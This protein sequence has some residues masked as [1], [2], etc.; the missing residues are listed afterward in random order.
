M[1]IESSKYQPFVRRY[2]N[3]NVTVKSFQQERIVGNNPTIIDSMAVAHGPNSPT[4]AVLRVT[5][6]YNRC[7]VNNSMQ[8]IDIPTMLV[9]LMNRLGK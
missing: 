4:P 5:V 9:A 8:S 2:L 7:Y 1:M 6:P 3:V